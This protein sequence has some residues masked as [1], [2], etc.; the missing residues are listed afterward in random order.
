[1]KLRKVFAVAALASLGS[2]AMAQV[3]LFED[4][5]EAY[6]APAELN[7]VGDW[8]VPSGTWAISSAQNNT[9]GG[10]K[11]LFEAKG[12]SATQVIASFTSQAVGAGD[13]L[14][15]TYYTYG[16]NLGANVFRSGFTLAAF[17]GGSWGSGG[18][19]ELIAFGWYHSESLTNFGARVFG[20]AGW[21]DA[22]A[23]QAFA[24]DGWQKLVI[25]C[26][27]GTDFSFEANDSG[28]PYSDNTTSVTPTLGFNGLRL[29]SYIGSGTANDLDIYYDDLS[30]V[31]TGASSID[32]WHMY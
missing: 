6:T 21:A 10:S 20:G 2:V 4:D 5:F 27:D 11:S 19:E 3:T 32:N 8:D 22:G 28:A 30:V 18:L 14:E 1:M 7:T 29:G 15:V 25:T 9:G 16:E 23:G 24:L 26:T 17:D 13:T 31:F 12:D